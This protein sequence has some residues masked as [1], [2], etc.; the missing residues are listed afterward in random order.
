M[1][2][3]WLT[4]DTRARAIISSCT[5][6]RDPMS[7]ADARSFC[8][9]LFF[10]FIPRGTALVE[11]ENWARLFGTPELTAVAPLSAPAM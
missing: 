7:D 1:R 11:P 9:R 2:L 8:D 10:H 4:H 3:V 5:S 6:T